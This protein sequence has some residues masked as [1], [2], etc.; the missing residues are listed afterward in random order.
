[1][2]ECP[3]VNSILFYTKK[4]SYLGSIKGVANSINYYPQ[5]II[6]KDTHTY[7]CK[8]RY[9]CCNLFCNFYSLG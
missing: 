2:F 7:A 3:L 8:H 6:S 9:I 1:M 4:I 5:L